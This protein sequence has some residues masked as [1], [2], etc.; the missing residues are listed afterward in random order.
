VRAGMVE[1]TDVVY[2]G[3]EAE[4]SRQSGSPVVGVVLGGSERRHYSMCAGQTAELVL[5]MK[6]EL[7]KPHSKL[8]T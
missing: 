5:F 4:L 3:N 6:S 1:T 7:V 2:V 8:R